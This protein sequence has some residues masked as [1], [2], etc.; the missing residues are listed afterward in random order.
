MRIFLFVLA[1]GLLASAG[2]AW[3]CPMMQSASKGE[4]VASSNGKA[5]STPIPAKSSQ[6]DQNG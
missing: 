6:Q 4:V 5:P 2:S 3:A 1:A